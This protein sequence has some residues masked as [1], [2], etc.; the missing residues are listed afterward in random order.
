MTKVTSKKKK[1]KQGDVKLKISIGFITSMKE[2][3]GFNR[4]RLYRQMQ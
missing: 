3:Y 2:V 1:A 4:Q